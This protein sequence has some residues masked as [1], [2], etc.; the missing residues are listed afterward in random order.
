MEFLILLAILAMG[1]LFFYFLIRIVAYVCVGLGI[2][3]IAVF[4]VTEKALELS[5]DT[6]LNASGDDLEVGVW[7]GELIVTPTG[8]SEERKEIQ[9][10]KRVAESTPDGPARLRV[11]L[12]ILAFALLWI[13][14]VTC[15]VYLGNQ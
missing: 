9:A 13:V 15:S 7:D 6:T 10:A 12:I 14:L 1:I 2:T 8:R 3:A 4:K 5:E 11:V